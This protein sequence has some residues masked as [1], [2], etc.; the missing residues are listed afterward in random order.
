MHLLTSRSSAPQ[1]G[2]DMLALSLPSLDLIGH[3]F[4]PRS[5]EVQ[6]VLMRADV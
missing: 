5:H 3:E 4:G 1:P 2:T 6:D